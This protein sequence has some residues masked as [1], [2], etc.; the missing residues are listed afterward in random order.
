[1]TAIAEPPR[2]RQRCHSCRWF[3]PQAEAG[4][5]KPT[6]GHCWR[7]P[8]RVTTFV[9]ANGATNWSNDRPY[10]DGKEGCGEWQQ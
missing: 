8:P 3:A 1:M 4:E 6:G 9:D 2:L 5:F 7:F 10:M